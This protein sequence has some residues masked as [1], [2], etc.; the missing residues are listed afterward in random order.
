MPFISG[1]AKVNCAV[2]Y[3]QFRRGA[4]LRY[5]SRSPEVDKRPKSQEENEK[6]LKTI[7]CEAPDL[8]LPSQL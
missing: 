8:R 4:H 6:E 7:A 2:P 5:L 3:E 1:D